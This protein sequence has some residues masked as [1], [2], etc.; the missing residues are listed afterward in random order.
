MRTETIAGSFTLKSGREKPLHQHHPWVFS[1]SIQKSSSKNI[2]DGSLVQFLAH[3]GSYLATAYYNANSQ[4]CGRVLSW[5]ADEAIDDE[6]WHNRLQA[7]FERR[8]LLAISAETTA[9]RIVNAEADGLPGLIVDLYGEYLVVQFL[10]MGIDRHKEAIVR[11]LVDLIQPKGIL[12]RSDVDVR[13]KEGLPKSKGILWGNVPTEPITIR[14]HQ[15]NYEVDIWNGHKTGF[16]LDQREN[17]RTVS[18]P[19]FVADKDVLNLFSYTGGFGL[20]AAQNGA[21]SVTHVDSSFDALTQAERH[22]ELNQ[23]TD[24]P[25]EFISADVFQLLRHYRDT[26]RQFDLIVIDPPKFVQN[27][28]SLQRATRAYKDLNWLAFRLLRPNGVLATFSCS[29]LLSADLF[30]KVVFGALIDAHCDAQIIDW[31]WQSAD[32]PVSLT[33]PESL[34]LKGLLCRV[35]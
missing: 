4:I 24:V 22:A 10:T 25:M 2:P 17:R 12:E 11:Q 35:W 5:K 26:N 27:Q 28:G 34:Y 14:E 18:E 15:L 31:M 6:F 8:K 9:Y 33:I 13:E 1:G 21:K 29:G 16:Y 3:D 19:R 7:A 30:Q 20:S 23:L 32:H